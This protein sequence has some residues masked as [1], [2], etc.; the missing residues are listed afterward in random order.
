M[1]ETV[2]V[3]WTSFRESTYWWSGPG[4]IPVEWR[5]VWKTVKQWFS[6]DRIVEDEEK[7]CECLSEPLHILVQI[8]KPVSLEPEAQILPNHGRI[9]SS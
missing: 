2:C 4:P 3:L 1:K 8:V 5:S 6:W 9:P 7:Q